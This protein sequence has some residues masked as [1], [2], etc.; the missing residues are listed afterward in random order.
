MHKTNNE[1]YYLGIFLVGA[2]QE[3]LGGL[4]NLFG[5]TNVVHIDVDASGSLHF[6]QEIEGDT[7]SEVLGYVQYNQTELIERFRLSI[8]KALKSNK[9][10]NTDSAVLKKLYKSALE[11]YTYLIV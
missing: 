11:A 8:E 2:Y 6:N 10:K 1:P 3:I 9:I 5:D 7:I 4:H